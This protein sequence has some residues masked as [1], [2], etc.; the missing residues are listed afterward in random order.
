VNK[1]LFVVD[2]KDLDYQ[3]MKEYDR[4]EK[5]AANS[6]S[7]T[8]IL[9]KQL[10]DANTRIIITTIQKLDIFVSKNKAHDIYK[11]HIVIILTNATA[12][13]LATCTKKSSGHLSITIFSDLRERRFLP[14]IQAAVTSQEQRPK[15]LAINFIHIPSLT[16]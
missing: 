11:K 4:F 16:P 13:S 1:V 8:R 15:P 2:R 10:E 14:P 6:N 9:Q 7:S 5:G 3:T 12:R